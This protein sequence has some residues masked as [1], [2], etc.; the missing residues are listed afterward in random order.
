MKK[1]TIIIATYNAEKTIE[2]CLQSIVSQ[3]NNAVELCI[4]DGQSVDK[5]MQIVQQYQDHIDLVISEKDNGIYDAWNKGIRIT[6]GNWILF[7]G[8]DDM[9][10][11]NAISHY[12][13]RTDEVNNTV[14][15]IT[16]R[17]EYVTK[18]GDIIKTFGRNWQWHTARRMMNISH[19]GTL[20]NRNLFCNIGTYDTRYKIA[21][22]YELLL[23]KG[24]K[25]KSLFFP[26]IMVKMESGG[27]SFSKAALKEAKQIR[28]MHSGLS[29]LENQLIY[30]YQLILFYRAKLNLKVRFKER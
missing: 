1:I 11:E 25:L 3:K 22:D 24:N 12:L 10:T 5:T 30:Y 6:S 4:V 20:H 15:I 26:D 16:F 14:D 27:T 19:V 29:K 21:A 17:S 28:A 9:L 23:R 8:A 13:K 2:R 18:K 7:L